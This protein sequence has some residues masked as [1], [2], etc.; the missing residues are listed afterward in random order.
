MYLE[1]YSGCLTGRVFLWDVA[2]FT[3]PL[4]LVNVSR[5]EADEDGEVCARKVLTCRRRIH[6]LFD[7]PHLRA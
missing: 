1:Q 6:V 2:D 4:A 7:E 5:R 3:T